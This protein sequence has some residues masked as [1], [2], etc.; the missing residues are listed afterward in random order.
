M[1]RLIRLSG[2]SQVRPLGCRPDPMC[3]VAAPVSGLAMRQMMAGLILVSTAAMVGCQ[4]GPL[5]ALKAANPYYSMNEWKKDEEIGVTDHERREQLTLLADTIAT[6]APERQQVWS[7]HLKRMIEN[8]QSPEMRRL[9][10]LAAGNI[11][12]GSALALVEKGLDDESMKVRMQACDSLG[13]LRS[14]QAA[15]LL[16]STLGTETNLDVKHRAMESLAKHKGS[17][18][19]DSL[20]LA[21]SD[22]NPATRSL[23]MQ[24]LRGVTGKNYGNDPDTWIAALDGKPAAEAEIRIADRVRDLW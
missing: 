20:R 16:A 21:L 15:R 12:D 23:A 2:P 8:D 19:T 13:D 9:A 4:D 6:M 17:I 1:S 14:D 18:A 10:V 24:S 7:E 22:R 11:K 5:Y 3:R